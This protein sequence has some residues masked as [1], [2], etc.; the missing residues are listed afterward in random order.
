MG[1]GNC[2]TVVI[3][4]GEQSQEQLPPRPADYSYTQALLE[5]IIA[6]LKEIYEVLLI[7]DA[8]EPKSEN[9]TLTTANIEYP[10]DIPN[11]TTQF[12]FQCKTNNELRYAFE[13]DKV[14]NSVRPYFTLKAGNAYTVKGVNLKNKRIY[15]ASSTAGVVVD[16]EAWYR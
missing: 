2:Q 7:G 4:N 8:T 12:S 10:W 6:R 13:K 1:N 16:I 5:S 11:G 15:F 14:V 9:L 3:E